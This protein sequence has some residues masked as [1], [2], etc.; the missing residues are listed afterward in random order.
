MVS[1][2]G[3]LKPKAP[4]MFAPHRTANTDICQPTSGLHA[5][6]IVSMMTWLDR[7]VSMS[8][9]ESRH[10]TT[11]KCMIFHLEIT[12]MMNMV[13]YAWLRCG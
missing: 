3:L 13:V 2:F 4:G 12:G 5:Q 10:C 7:L 9:S 8:C 1:N 6:L 11:N